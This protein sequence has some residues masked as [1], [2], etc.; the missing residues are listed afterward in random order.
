MNQ[1]IDEAFKIH[2]MNEFLRGLGTD[3][4]IEFQ[5]YTQ[6]GNLL[7]DIQEEIDGKFEYGLKYT[8]NRKG[9]AQFEITE[10]FELE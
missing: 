7:M 4:E 2:I 9:F 8:H 1:L 5:S 6:Y 3:K 10:I